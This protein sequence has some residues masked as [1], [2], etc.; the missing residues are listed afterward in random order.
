[1]RISDTGPRPHIAICL[2]LLLAV[3]FAERANA[4]PQA[5]P[6]GQQATSPASESQPSPSPATAAN[7]AATDGS[8]AAAGQSK[9]S[10]ERS[11]PV[12]A[13]NDA[14]NGPVGTASSSSDQQQTGNPEPVGTAAAPYE[15]TTGVAASRPAGAV[16]A[17]AK[18]KRARSFLIRVAVILGAAAAIGTVVGLSAGSA[19]RP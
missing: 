1:M 2:V 4:L 16:I 18:Q 9:I 12:A 5:T 15:K 8:V 6:T 14:A 19:N 3:P 7:S 13:Q 11:A 10:N 17:P